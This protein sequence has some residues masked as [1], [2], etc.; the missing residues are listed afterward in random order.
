MT[1]LA[2]LRKIGHA[3]A[4]LLSPLTRLNLKRAFTGRNKKFNFTSTQESSQ[5]VWSMLFKDDSWFQAI[6]QVQHTSNPPN[7]TLV[8]TDVAKLYSGSSTSVYAVLMLSDWG[9]DCRYLKDVFFAS[10]QDHNYNKVSHEVHFRN[11]NII[12]NVQDVVAPDIDIAIK[13]PRRLFS[14]SNRK[15][16]TT[17]LY[18]MDD[19]LIKIGHDQ[20]GSVVDLPTKKMKSIRYMCCLPL[21]FGDGTPIYQIIEKKGPIPFKLRVNETKVENGRSWIMSWRLGPD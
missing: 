13:D 15:F 8:G 4:A 6:D 11:S 9:G 21:H 7:P 19:R 2:T 17:A 20:I 3:I 10:L 12:L 14:C 1:I 16:E 18:Y 5:K